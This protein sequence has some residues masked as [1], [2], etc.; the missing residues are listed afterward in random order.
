MSESPLKQ[1]ITAAMKDAMRSKDKERLG[2]IRLALSEIKRIEVDERID[3]DDTRILGILDKMVKQRRE[4][5]K[6]FEAGK[7]QE[8]ADVEQAE[9][10]VLQDFMP[11]ALT[12]EEIEGIL[13]AALADSGAKTMQDMGKVMAL[14]K[15]QVLGKADMGIVS[16]KIKA[17]LD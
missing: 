5:I 7:R 9:I 1:E 16:Q 3:P 8:L 10:L 4:S 2:T 12:D 15:P 11:K 13:S 14:I 6:Q 17:A